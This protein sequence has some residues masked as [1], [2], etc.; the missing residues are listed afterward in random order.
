MTQA[1]GLIAT[2]LCQYPQATNIIWNVN[3]TGL[4]QLNLK[5][6]ENLIV[7]S[8][9]SLSDSMGG[10]VNT[11][12]LNITALSSY[13]DTEVRCVALLSNETTE[14]SSPVNLTVQGDNY[15]YNC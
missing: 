8:F 13:N 9:T 4:N 5:P 1:E 3:G 10:S 15:K 11:A 2:F 14:L 7:T 6:G 12:I